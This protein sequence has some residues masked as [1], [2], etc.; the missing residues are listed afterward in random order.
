MLV[1]SEKPVIIRLLG[2]VLMI[3]TLLS[4][5]PSAAGAQQAVID[6]LIKIYRSQPL[7]KTEQINVLYRIIYSNIYK[8]GTSHDSDQ[9]LWR[10][11]VNYALPGLTLS[12]EMQDDYH[13]MGFSLWL[14]GAYVLDAKYDS[15]RYY[16]EKTLYYADKLKDK[17]M[18][19]VVYW[20]SV[21]AYIREGKFFEASKYNWKLKLIARKVK[22]NDMLC[23]ADS[24]FGEI[25]RL[26]K[27]YERAKFCLENSRKN[28]ILDE[29]FNTTEIAMRYYY[30]SGYI[31]MEEGNLDLA[32]EYEKHVYRISTELQYKVFTCLSTE[33]LAK[34]YI[35][36]NDFHKAMQFLD[37]GLCLAKELGDTYLH[38]KIWN[39]YSEIFLV[40]KRYRD[41]AD[42]AM[43]AWQADSTAVDTGPE[44]AGN[45]AISHMYM[46]NRDTAEYFFR[47]Y[48][49]LMKRHEDT[50]RELDLRYQAELQNMRIAAL[51]KERFFFMLTAILTILVIAVVFVFYR[52]QRKVAMQKA[53][54]DGAAREREYLA[55][56]LHDGLGRS[57]STTRLCLTNLPES[58]A[59][60]RMLDQAILEMRNF[61]RHI[62]PP[63]LRNYGI[64]AAVEDVCANIPHAIFHHC[65]GDRRYELL[66]EWHA[67][68]CVS[69]LIN[70]A[71]KH[72]GAKQINIYLYQEDKRIKFTVQDNGCGFNPATVVRGMGFNNLKSR[73]AYCRG[74]ITIDTAPGEGAEI[75]V[76]LNAH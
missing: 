19:S 18:E 73:L 34:I 2:A 67:Y 43:K 76:V 13:A 41:C 48:D 30:N 68:L 10:R 8:E 4:I 26:M 72:S 56:S 65:S 61:T 59:A 70:N 51:E 29:L 37:E 49:L 27:H 35:R 40:Q 58:E 20:N 45:I 32:L 11:V 53:M 63:S 22:R 12:E 23:M 50:L 28:Y 62:F 31:A 16:H 47:K 54:I 33:A 39:V 38:I 14:A 52:K 44:I 5:R 15:T 24:Y 71:I 57:L 6:S 42:T 55:Q 69:E 46:G 36:L 17:R 66:L 21:D 1:K 3:T 75:S 74:R 7:D 9:P 60:C 64:R 25:Y